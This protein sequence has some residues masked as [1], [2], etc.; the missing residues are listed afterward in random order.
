MMLVQ[1]VQRQVRERLTVSPFTSSRLLS[2]NTDSTRIMIGR[3]RS[4]LLDLI[5]PF[6]STSLPFFPL[7]LLEAQL[8][9]LLI[10]RRKIEFS[11]HTRHYNHQLCHRERLR[12]AVPRPDLKRPVRSLE[13]IQLVIWSDEP[14]FRK[15]FVGALPVDRG[16]LQLAMDCEHDRDVGCWTMFAGGSSVQSCHL[17][18]IQS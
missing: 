17:E 10:R 12:N 8:I 7:S 16:A 5:R 3:M 6:P 9:K 14:A 13:G 11:H 1:R 18:S 4:S 2:S 15:K